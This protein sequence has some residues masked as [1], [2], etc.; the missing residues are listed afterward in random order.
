MYCGVSFQQVTHFAL[1]ESSYFF[2]WFL[3]IRSLPVSRIS[4][5][6]WFVLGLSIKPMIS[7]SVLG[8]P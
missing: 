6:Y 4:P 2:M 8:L 3:M 1:G 7:F 5:R